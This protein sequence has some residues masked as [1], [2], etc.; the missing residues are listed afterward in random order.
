ML[1]TSREQV[2]ALPAARLRCLHPEPAAWSGP[3]YGVK[4]ASK[5]VTM[6]RRASRADSSW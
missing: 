1:E 5:N 6:R 4:R 2:S 3:V